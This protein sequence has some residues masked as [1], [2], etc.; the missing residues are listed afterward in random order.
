MLTW[1]AA[2]I[3]GAAACLGCASWMASLSLRIKPVGT[4]SRRDVLEIRRSVASEAFPH[5]WHGFSWYTVC[6]FR[7][8]LRERRNYRVGTITQQADDSVTAQL[9]IEGFL[10]EKYT[11]RKTNEQWTITGLDDGDVYNWVRRAHW[12]N[13]VILVRT[14][15]IHL[16]KMP[17]GHYH[18]LEGTAA[19][20][21]SY[22]GTWKPGETVNYCKGIE[23]WSEKDPSNACVGGLAY[24][25]LDEHSTNSIGM[26]TG[27]DL[28]YGY[29]PIFEE[30]LRPAE[31][32]KRR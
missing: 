19:V 4:L 5:V 11:L 20:V 17:P 22:K 12:A 24:F 16:Q 29:L 13:H 9:L 6:N 15:T 21:R 3:I 28:D 26:D 2:R 14:S 1:K 27:D 23:S 7:G 18:H 10:A 25:L 30:H 8:S 31:P 32:A